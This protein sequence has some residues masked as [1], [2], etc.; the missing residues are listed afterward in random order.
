M[1]VHLLLHFE[2][3]RTLWNELFNGVGLAW[4]M[5]RRVIDFLA[6]WRGLHDNSKIAAE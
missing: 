6:I 3:A 2:I 5:P 4:L 1:A